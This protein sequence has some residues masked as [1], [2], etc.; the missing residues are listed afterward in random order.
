VTRGQWDCWTVSKAWEPP[1]PGAIWLKITQV[2]DS[3][4]QG[5][6]YKFP[7][8]NLLV[9]NICLVFSPVTVLLLQV[10]D[11]IFMLTLSEPRV[12]FLSLDGGWD[13]SLNFTSTIC[14]FP[15]YT[16]NQHCFDHWSS[17]SVF[18]KDTGSCFREESIIT[19][20]KKT[21]L[22]LGLFYAVFCIAGNQTA[23]LETRPT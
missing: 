2:W 22:V 1:Q 14:S 6:D 12:E 7:K 13:Q 4:A 10:A 21:A 3:W 15:W 23:H 20:H 11:R 19:Y 8:M 5:K 18:H 9:L 17:N 16:R